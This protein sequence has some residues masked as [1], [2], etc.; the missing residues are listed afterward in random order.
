M[1]FLNFFFLKQVF[2]ETGIDI[3]NLINANEYVESTI[4]DQLIR[5]YFIV[6]IDKDINFEPQTRCEIKAVKWFPIEQL[7]VSKK[8]IIVKSRAYEPRYFYMVI[9][10]MKYVHFLYTFY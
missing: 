5:L 3:S 2:E 7:P 10:F 1:K 4:H 6:G 8:D 9:P